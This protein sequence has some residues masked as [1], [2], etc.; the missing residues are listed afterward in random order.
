MRIL[1]VVLLVASILAQNQVPCQGNVNGTLWDLSP[2]T[3]DP[4]GTPPIGYSFS[5]IDGSANTYYINFCDVVAPSISNSA[6]SRRVA[7]PGS[8]QLSG[9]T[10]YNAGAVS[11]M[12]WQDFTPDASG[13]TNSGVAIQYSS[14]DY[15]PGLGTYRS[16]T[17]NVGCDKDA[18]QGKLYSEVASGCEYTLFFKSEYGCQDE[19]PTQGPTCCFYFSSLQSY[20]TAL[21][22][23]GG[24]DCPTIN[25]FYPVG[26]TTISSCADCFVKEK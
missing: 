1:F 24:F 13:I 8:C 2:L 26:N 17:I 12:T 19:T 11:T 4:E 23:E 18:G 7:N 16:S 10:Y 3:Y 20:E 9:A 14:G 6:C 25:N 5:A 21:C 22:Q 15:C